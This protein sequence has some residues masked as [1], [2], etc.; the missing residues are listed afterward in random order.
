MIHFVA[1]CL[2]S[3]HFNKD[4]F[5]NPMGEMNWK[6][7]GPSTAEKMGGTNALFRFRKRD[8]TYLIILFSESKF[9]PSCFCD[10]DLSFFLFLPVRLVSLAVCGIWN[11]T[12][13]RHRA[14]LTVWG[15]HPATSSPSSPGFTSPVRADI[16]PSVSILTSHQSTWWINQTHFRF[17]SFITPLRLCMLDE[18]LM[19]GRDLE[20]QLEIRL[21]SDS[22]LLLHTGAKKTQQLSLYLN[23]GQVTQ[24]CTQTYTDKT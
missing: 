16:W 24:P 7:S 13:W 17:N 15:W 23:Q 2:G 10:V 4:L 18:S 1:G 20:I 5:V 12:R 9:I 8:C 6:N 14:P 22:G 19:L 3:W 21:V 11:W